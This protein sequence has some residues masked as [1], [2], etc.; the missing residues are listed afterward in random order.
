MAPPGSLSGRAGTC[1]ATA[2]L[3]LTISYE[4]VA[5][6]RNGPLERL[7]TFG[8]GMGQTC[9]GAQRTFL[10]ALMPERASDTANA[11]RDSLGDGNRA[12]VFPHPVTKSSNRP[13]KAALPVRELVS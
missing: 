3:A 2:C 12:T 6:F 7:A 8:P 1:E 13:L 9:Q 11:V 4:A 10:I 5:H